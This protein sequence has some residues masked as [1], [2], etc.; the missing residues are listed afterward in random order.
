MYCDIVLRLI[1]A[2]C[3]LRVFAPSERIVFDPCCFGAKAPCQPLLRMIQST[4][5]G[6]LCGRSAVATN[7]WN[8]VPHP[9]NPADTI[10]KSQVQTC[11][12]LTGSFLEPLDISTFD[13][14]ISILKSTA[15]VSPAGVDQSGKESGV[16][17][18]GDIAKGQ[19]HQWPPWLPLGLTWFVLSGDLVEL[20]PLHEVPARLRAISAV[21]QRITVFSSW[22]RG[23]FEG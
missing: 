1:A 2:L 16:F 21:L 20:C 4:C 19:G 23:E 10:A 7:R 9:V 3:L 15:F 12:T 18:S 8:F 11:Q 14:A 13:P 6:G 17:S 22:L 5:N